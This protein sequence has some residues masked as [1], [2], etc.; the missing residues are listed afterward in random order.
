MGDDTNDGPPAAV[1]IGLIMS[2][3]LAGMLLL[4]GLIGF[5]FSWAVGDRVGVG[6]TLLGLL[7]LGATYIAGKGS[8]LGRAF[9]GLLT[10]FLAVA[11][12][13]YMFKGPTSAIFP[14]IMVV[15]ISA[16]TFALLF[17]PEKSKRFYA[18]D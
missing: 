1:G 10:G 12:V 7:V 3:G 17:L 8:R 13:I 2:Y 14:S 15:V 18:E 5:L 6:T 11:A 16:G 4:C 9:I